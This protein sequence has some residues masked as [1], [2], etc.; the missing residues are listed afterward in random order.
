MTLLSMT[1]VRNIQSETV[2]RNLKKFREEASMTQA[3]AAEFSG[4]ALD[5]LRRYESGKT[6]KVPW[7]ALTDLSYIYGH[8]MDDFFEESPPKA[9]LEAIPTFS[10]RARPRANV[11]EKIFRDLQSQIE[12][13]NKEVLKKR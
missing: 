10:L 8:S 9:K 3:E 11:D 2:R 13:A 7:R 12:K 1:K 4:V 6:E 5:N